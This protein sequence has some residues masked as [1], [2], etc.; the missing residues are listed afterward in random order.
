MHPHGGWRLWLGIALLAANGA[1][2][3]R[4]ASD[5]TVILAV[6]DG[7]APALVDAF[8]TPALDRMRREGAWTHHMEPAFPTISLIN[9]VT[10]STGCWPAHHG[11]VTNLFWDPERGVYD[12]DPDADWLAGCEHLHQVAERQGVRTAALAWYGSHSGLHGPLATYVEERGRLCGEGL[13]A[14]FDPPR[15][16]E[17][18]RLLN[19]PDGER[20]GL[21]LA[22]FCGPDAAEHFRGMDSDETR[23]AV[24]QSDAILGTLLEAVEALPFRDR[25]TLVVTTDHGMAPVTTIVNVQRILGRLG[26]A[27]RFHSTGTTSFLYL[28][29]PA[30]V[31]PAARAL[32]EYDEFEVLR[33]DA[34]PPWAHLGNGARAG[35][36]V[37]SARPPYFIEDVARWPVWLRWLGDWG[38]EFMWARF[39]LKASHGYPPDVP[40]MAGILYA[41]GDGIARG[42]EVERV[43]AIDVHPT[44]SHLLGIE[45]GRPVDGEVARALLAGEGP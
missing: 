41:W 12:H 7:F 4:A 28:D 30:A 2:P 22:Y 19:L 1:A 31:E 44:V 26:I 39:S 20:P 8:D 40:G 10:I 14:P 32:A 34:L 16:E 42:R 18:V 21:L 3:A 24:A 9:G 5:R 17:L 33:T 27:A 6:F 29:D 45:T 23:R 36:L 13:V 15:A 35:D 38:P 37:L 11:I 25:V 43:R